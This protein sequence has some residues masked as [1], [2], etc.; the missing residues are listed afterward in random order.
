MVM[1]LMCF[2]MCLLF[3]ATSFAN[4]AC[5]KPKNDF[6][7]LYCLSKVYQEADKELNDNFKLLAGKL[8]ADGKKSLKSGQLAWIKDRNS[9]CSE[10]RGNSFLVDLDCDHRQRLSAVNFCK[11]VCV[12]AIAQVVKTANC[13]FYVYRHWAI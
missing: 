6:D 1:K 4:S 5:D 3:S 2:F 10:A 13:N 7:G 12:N 9:R 8:D 11:I